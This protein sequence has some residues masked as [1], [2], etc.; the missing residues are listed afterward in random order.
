LIFRYCGVRNV[1][2]KLDPKFSQQ[3]QHSSELHRRFAVFDFTDED[4]PDAGGARRVVQTPVLRVADRSNQEAEL[5]NRIHSHEH[6]KPLNRCKGIYYDSQTVSERS[7]DVIASFIRATY[8][9]I[10][11]Q[12]WLAALRMGHAVSF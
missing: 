10:P 3:P 4:V 12:H 6:E 1:G 5:L 7:K 8:L 11:S 2:L 9:L